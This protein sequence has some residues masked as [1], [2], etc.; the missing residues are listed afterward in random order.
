MFAAFLILYVASM[1]FTSMNLIRAVEGNSL[2]LVVED[3]P[4]AD[5]IVVLGG[6]IDWIRT[7]HGVAPEW[8]DSD[9]FWDGVALLKADKAPKLI[10]TGGKL[11]WQL[12]DETEGDVLKRFAVIAQVS[13]KQILVTGKVQNTADEAHAVAQVLE[14]SKIRIILVT[15]AFHMNRAKALFDKQGFEVFSYPVDFKVGSGVDWSTAF[16]PNPNALVSTDLCIREL[17]GRLYYRVRS[18]LH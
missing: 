2:K 3:V 8:G 16:L 9:R 4:N 11:P 12:G 18:R 6:M 10:F 15:S 7:S 14:P 17:L 1:P 13:E 5:A